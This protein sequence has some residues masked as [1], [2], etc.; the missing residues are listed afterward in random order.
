LINHSYQKNQAP[1]LKPFFLKTW[2]ANHALPHM[3]MI[4]TRQEQTTW[5]ARSA[6]YHFGYNGEPSYPF[7]FAAGLLLTELDS[8]EI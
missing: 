4:M 1:Q 5:L 6:M 8:E 3:T 7:T 2:M